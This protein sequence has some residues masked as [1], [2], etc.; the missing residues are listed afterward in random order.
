MSYRGR[1]KPMG[2]RVRRSVSVIEGCRVLPTTNGVG[3]SVLVDQCRLNG[4]RILERCR[5]Q[6]RRILSLDRRQYLAQL[7]HLGASQVRRAPRVTLSRRQS[8]F[9]STYAFLTSTLHR[10]TLSL[11]HRISKSRITIYMLTKIN[12]Q[13]KGN[14]NKE[15]PPLSN[16]LSKPTKTN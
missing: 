15:T 4:H 10:N 11:I 9:F 16:N 8:F 6:W 2:T 1:L 13:S 14:C 5:R 7:A 3:G 12:S